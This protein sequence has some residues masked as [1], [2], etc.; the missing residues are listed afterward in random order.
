MTKANIPQYSATAASNTDVQDIDIAEN[1][2]PSG[3]NNAIREIMA[4]LK[5]QDTGAVAMTSPVA[6]SLTVTNEITANGG[7]ALGDNDKATFGAS[8]DLQIYHDGSH[9]YVKDAG[10]G[11]LKLQGA[12]YV[13]LE[14]DEGNI[15]LRGQKNNA[16][17]LYYNGA[18][19]LATTATGVDVT[20]DVTVSGGVAFSDAGSS[21]TSNSNLLDDYE[22]GTWTPVYEGT[23][24]AGSNTYDKQ[25]GYYTKIGNL[26]TATLRIRTDALSGMTGNLR[27]AGLPFSVRNLAAGLD[28]AAGGIVVHQADT[29]GVNYPTSGYV[30][31]NTSTVL[32]SYVSAINA[33][34]SSLTIADLG[35][36][37]NANDMMATI[38]YFTAT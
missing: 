36:G 13:L 20:G 38:T 37:A 9:S 25:L 11:N 3:I 31:D 30:V 19:K 17:L 26:V 7:I 32:L 16:L 33:D 21:G 23:S 35:T 12:S 5:D 1:C 18:I 8:D 15:M 34:P 24:G 6:T 27:L 10:A 29:F 28:G 2:A 4:D 14:S 22:E